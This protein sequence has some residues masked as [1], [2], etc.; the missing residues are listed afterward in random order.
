MLY[1]MNVD[2][3]GRL[4]IIIGGGVVAERK[5]RGIL[6]LDAEVAVR[7]IAP[8][9][10]DVLRELADCEQIEWR[11]EYYAGGMLEGAFLVYAA[12]DSPSVNAEIAAE[13]KRLGLLVN[14]ID[15]PNASSFQLPAT[16]R[17]G[18]FLLTVSTGGGSP[19]L[20]RAIWME[21]EQL[22]PPTFGLWLERVA[23]LRS[24]LQEALPSSRERT[25]FWRMA[26]RPHLLD[27][28]RNGEL[29]KAE[30][31]LRNAALDIGAKS[32]NGSS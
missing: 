13:A 24:E 26:L 7:V 21:M 2:L 14:V 15:D 3:A 22:Y 12:T 5:V 32:S 29:E 17:R 20:S 25:C 9:M 18:D 27:M 10:T 16:L 28:I 30:V 4:V 23:L 8:A 6:A 19:A 1:P 11:E 31:E